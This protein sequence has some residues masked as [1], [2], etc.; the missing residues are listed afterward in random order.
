M[1][2]RNTGLRWEV[3]AGGSKLRGG[4]KGQKRKVCFQM[5]ASGLVLEKQV[6]FSYAL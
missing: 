3:G 5:T 4:D 1:G 2:K 6:C